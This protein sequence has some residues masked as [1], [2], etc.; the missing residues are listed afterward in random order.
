MSLE[1]TLEI[2]LL[3]LVAT[4]IFSAATAQH[5]A[6]L[7]L[8]NTYYPRNQS[9]SVYTCTVACINGVSSPPDCD[10]SS[11][12]C[13][14]SAP[15]SN[16]IDYACCL[17]SCIG[18][19]QGEFGLAS[20]QMPRPANLA[21]TDGTRNIGDWCSSV[22]SRPWEP[23]TCVS[24]QTTPNPPSRRSWNGS[25]G[26]N[27]SISSGAVAGLVIGLMSGFI[28]L[29]MLI[30]CC[31]GRSAEQPVA[32]DTGPTLPLHDIRSHGHDQTLPHELVHRDE[33]PP[34]RV[35]TPPPAYSEVPLHREGPKDT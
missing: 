7:N 3:S 29:I 1:M 21:S 28:A 34:P 2:A 5:N 6:L 11:K 26:Q 8:T 27:G 9:Y 16:L 20:N 13:W 35:Q 24:G 23:P 12:S 19:V 10:L 32:T 14:C 15:D 33:L 30:S 4:T 31:C 17:S 22:I 18:P 25:D